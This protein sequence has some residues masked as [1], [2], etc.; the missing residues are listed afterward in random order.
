MPASG[1]PGLLCFPWGGSGRRG[2]GGKGEWGAGGVGGVQGG[3]VQ[4]IRPTELVRRVFLCCILARH[5]WGCH[6]PGFLVTVT[7]ERAHGARDLGG[8]A[9][10]RCRYDGSAGVSG[11]LCA[12]VGAGN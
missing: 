2:V 11:L 4:S 3:E 6:L 5:V 10:L 12:R 8:G 7:R 9:L 1:D